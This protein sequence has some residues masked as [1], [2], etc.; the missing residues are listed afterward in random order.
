MKIST[1]SAIGEIVRVNFK[2]AQIFENYGIDFCCGGDKTLISVCSEREIDM[3]ELISSVEAVMESDDPDSKYFL[4]LTPDALIEYI[5]NRHHSYVN[6][7]IPF[8]SQKLEKLCNVHGAHHPELFEI[9]ELF[10]AAAG[11][12]SQHMKKEELIVFPLIRKI[13]LAKQENKKAEVGENLNSRIDEMSEE[14][15]AEGERFGKISELSD[16]YSL[17]PDGCGTY[18][19]TLKTLSEFEQDLH[20]HIHLES[21][22]LFPTALK[23]EKDLIL[24]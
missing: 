6:E 1:N 24:I 10:A 12:L 20:K 13:Y 8:L 11:N 3:N 14:H 23:M 17:P 18:D 4:S 2:T 9:M 22:I 5:I 19:V 21:N 16:N 15:S 7:T